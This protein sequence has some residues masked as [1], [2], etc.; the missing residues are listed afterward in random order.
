MTGDNFQQL[1]SE[2]TC[3]EIAKGDDPSTRQDNTIE[4][5]VATLKCH[6]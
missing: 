5:S 2:L 6:I 1:L 4:Q 3:A